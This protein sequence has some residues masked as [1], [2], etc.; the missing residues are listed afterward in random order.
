MKKEGYIQLNAHMRI[1][2]HKNLKKLAIEEGRTMAALL[3]E[4]VEDLIKKKAK[5][6]K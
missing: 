5:K 6:K 4:A 3:E 2:L 1:P